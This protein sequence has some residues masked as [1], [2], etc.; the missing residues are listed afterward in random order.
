M[1]H[2]KTLNFQDAQTLLS[3]LEQVLKSGY[4]V[5]STVPFQIY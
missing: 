1:K 2:S 3:T 5:L 4:Y